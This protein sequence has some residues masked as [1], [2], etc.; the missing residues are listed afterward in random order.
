MANEKGQF[1]NNHKIF[2]NKINGNANLDIIQI[3]DVYSQINMI[4]AR[5]FLAITVRRK[6]RCIGVKINTLFII[7]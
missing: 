3:K 4:L 7:L 5:M 1:K 2:F 6:L